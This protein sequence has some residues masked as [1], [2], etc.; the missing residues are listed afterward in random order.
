MP[1][2]IPIREQ[3]G[4]IMKRRALGLGAVASLFALIGRSKAR[5]A[6]ALTINPNGEVSIDKLSVKQSLGVAGPTTIS[7]KNT[8][9]FGAGVSSKEVSA[10]KIGYQTFTADALDIVGAGDAYANRKIKFWAA[11]G[12]TLDGSL[13]VSGNVT[14]KGALPVGAILMWS[15]DPAKLPAGWALC[16]GRPGTPN[17]QGR[18]V[19]GYHPA[20]PDYNRI[21][22]IGG[23]ERH[24]LELNEIPD[25][26]HPLGQRIEYIANHTHRWAGSETTGVVQ[27]MDALFAGKQSPSTG[28]MVF[29]NSVGAPHEN[30]PPYY[31]LAYI[32]YTG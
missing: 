30:R 2:S 10:G 21:H 31:V 20:Q 9:E 12:A 17:L 13:T 23:E 11:G 15:G 16:D 22:N 24:K 3:A 8:L 32:M 1:R 7:G 26:T 14:G 5:A 27:G 25:H 4:K 6:D 28:K 18:F 19:V 29:A